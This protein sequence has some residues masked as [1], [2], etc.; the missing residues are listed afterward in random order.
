MKKRATLLV[1]VGCAF[2]SPAMAAQPKVDA[3]APDFIV[4]LFDKTKVSLAEMRG[5]V[6]VINYWATWC[7]PCKAE[8]PMMDLYHRRNKARGFEI[9]GVVTK[10]SLAPSK[11]KQL[12]S[13]LSYPLALNL[14]GKYGTI[15]EA[16]PTSY[17]IDRKGMIRYAKA[18]SFQPEQFKALIDPL[19]SEA[20]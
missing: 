9:F 8:M 3:V 6:V 2:L 7:G 12:A 17:I 18:G 13:V 5:K 10:D 20:P 19:L 1:I 4:T 11:L 14:K 15:G 16:V